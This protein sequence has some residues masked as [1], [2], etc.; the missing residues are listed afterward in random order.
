ME[1]GS[2]RALRRM[3]GGQREEGSPY[4]EETSADVSEDYCRRA[5]KENRKA[6]WAKT[7]PLQ[8]GVRLERE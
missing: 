8:P 6:L 2:G 5:C 7:R 3:A 4:E 1:K